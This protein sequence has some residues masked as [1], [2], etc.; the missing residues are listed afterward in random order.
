MEKEGIVPRP[1]IDTVQGGRAI[2]IPI[3]DGFSDTNYILH[4][5]QEIL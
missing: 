5:Q 3:M 2:I 1:G 4:L